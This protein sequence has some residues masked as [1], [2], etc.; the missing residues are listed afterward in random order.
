MHLP[1]TT[2]DFGYSGDEPI[3][4]MAIHSPSLHLFGF[5]N[6]MDELAVRTPLLRTLAMPE[7]KLEETPPAAICKTNGKGYAPRDSKLTFSVGEQGAYCGATIH[8]AK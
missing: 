7:R 3:L 1:D 6:T 5:L 2:R 8:I 4:L